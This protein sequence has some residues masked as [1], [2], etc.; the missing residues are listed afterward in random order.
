[1]KRS[2]HPLRIGLFLLGGMALLVSA[3]VVVFGGQLFAASERG[4]LNFSGSV[5]GLQVGSPVVLRGVRVGS[6][7]DIGLAADDSRGGFAAPVTVSIN[8]ER[9]VQGAGAASAPAGGLLAQLVQRGLQGE[10]ALHS[11]LTG[12]QY[13]DLNLVAGAGATP[14]RVG[15][16]VEIP[17]RSTTAGGLAALQQL[18]VKS[19]VEDLSAVAAA[20]R[21][22][23]GGSA[24]KQ[25]LTDLSQ[26]AASLARL[27]N[28]LE[29]RLG[30]LSQGLQGTLDE[31][32]LAARALGTA[33]ERMGQMAERA[34]QTAERIGSAAD[35]MGG[36]AVRAEAMLAP[37]APLPR[38][39]QQAAEQVAQGAQALKRAAADD[40]P[41]MQNVEQTLQ[42]LRRTSRAVR[43]LAEL[44]ERQ[45]DAL[46]RGRQ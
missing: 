34:G 5:Y 42:E 13:V 18:D 15:G 6:V 24:L 14:K 19:L 8:P 26:M 10:L 9:V 12:Q 11:L 31:S 32:R 38:S 35:R 25:G 36:A 16:L 1:M 20:A 37:D 45:P 28:Q 29:Q 21:Q 23:V 17:T 7:V 27:S 44:L 40:S 2:S 3:V 4:V 30:P 39:L 46:L 22:F 33:A 43:E 41:A